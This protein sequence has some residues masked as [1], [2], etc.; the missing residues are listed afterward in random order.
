[1]KSAVY[2]S[3]GIMLAILVAI[4]LTACVPSRTP[5]VPMDY[6]VDPNATPETAC[7]ALTRLHCGEARPAAN[8]TS[9]P[10]VVRRMMRLRNVDLGCVTSAPDVASVRMC[11]GAVRCRE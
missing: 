9:C 2:V 1:M 11:T 5:V 7:G 4:V 10:D 3:L 8:G 6:V